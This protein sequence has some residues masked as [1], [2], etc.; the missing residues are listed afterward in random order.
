MAGKVRKNSFFAQKS[1]K[2][3]PQKVL[4]NTQFFFH[5]PNRRIH[6]PKCAAYRPTVYKTG[7]NIDGKK[8]QKL[9]ALKKACQKICMEYFQSETLWWCKECKV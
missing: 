6:V 8:Y 5:S 7:A 9:R 1:W 4:R 2:N 3:H